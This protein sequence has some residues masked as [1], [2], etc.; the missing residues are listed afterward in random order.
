MNKRTKLILE[1]SKKSVERGTYSRKYNK[2][3]VLVLFLELFL[4]TD[5]HDLNPSQVA[6]SCSSKDPTSNIDK[7]QSTDLACRY[8]K[9]RL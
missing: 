3:Y 8:F 2:L 1:L 7:I 6:G 5:L 4:S 9:I